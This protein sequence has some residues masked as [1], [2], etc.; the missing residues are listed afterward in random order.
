MSKFDLFINKIINIFLWVAI[1]S[2]IFLVIELFF[3]VVYQAL[4]C[5]PNQLYC[6]IR[7]E[8]PFLQV[9]ISMLVL[10]L[11]TFLFTTRLIYSLLV[12]DASL[13]NVSEYKESLITRRITF[14]RT[15]VY[16]DLRRKSE[17]AQRV[18]GINKPQKSKVKI[19]TRKKGSKLDE[20]IEASGL[21]STTASLIHELQEIKKVE[22]K[23][24][25]EKEFYTR[26][27]KNELIDIITRATSLNHKSADLF[28]N[29][30]LNVITEQLQ[31]DDEVKLSKFGK[32]KKV[33]VEAHKKV[34]KESGE[35][36]QIEAEST[37]YFYP[38][39]EFSNLIA[40]DSEITS[41]KV[42][43]TKTEMDKL[44]EDQVQDELIREE[45]IREHV[46]LKVI[47]QPKIEEDIKKEEAKM[48]KE[49]HAKVI[50]KT[51]KDIIK[52]ISKTS[53][54]S[55]NK[56]NKFLSDFEKVITEELSK[57]NEVHI[58]GLG[59]FLTIVMPRKEAMNPQTHKIIVVEEH[60]QVRLRMDSEFKKRFK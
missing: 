36:I 27:N 22:T 58:P 2:F 14:S 18:N 54:L 60:R 51:K 40:Q 52:Y 38:D 47:L 12:K 10:I 7:P 42:L 20:S 34:N 24:T 21:E 35:E 26:L 57:G 55:K 41:D 39:K 29:T 11:V 30:M 37:V 15:K 46:E 28:I 13:L 17:K 25:S 1:I 44:S 45:K 49:L 59:T 23:S 4:D 31:K 53:K 50:T 48:A 5:S 19:K 32:F 56:S 33:F 9:T 43:L 16:T 6:T 3:A 8:N